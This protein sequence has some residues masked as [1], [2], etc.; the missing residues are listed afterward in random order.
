MGFHLP[1]SLPT[2]I[3]HLQ[4]PGHTSTDPWLL[5]SEIFDSVNYGNSLVVGTSEHKL[6]GGLLNRLKQLN[7]ARMSGLS[8]TNNLEVLTGKL[9]REMGRKRSFVEEHA[10]NRRRLRDFLANLG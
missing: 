2:P 4:A 5:N 6:V 1:T 8:I 3:Q 7:G 10:Q 9:L